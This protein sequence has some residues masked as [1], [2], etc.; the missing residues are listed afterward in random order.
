MDIYTPIKKNKKHECKPLSNFP[1]GSFLDLSD[2]NRIKYIPS[3]Y[4]NLKFREKDMST[5]LQS[6]LQNKERIVP[7][8]GLCGIGKSVLARN[9]LHYVAERKMFSGGVLY[10]QMKNVRSFF[11][12][13]KIIMR[14]I[15]SFANLH[16]EEK[17][18]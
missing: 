7:I 4:E 13:V 15:M 5:L 6:L 17:L 3:K 12:V 9:T 18:L 1:E 8:L 10:I 11:A 16:Q 2:H 14:N